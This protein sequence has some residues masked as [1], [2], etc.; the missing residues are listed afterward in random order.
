MD[1]R[2]KIRGMFWG[3]SIGDALGMPVE[4]STADEIAEKYPWTKTYGMNRYIEPKDHK[5]FSNW[6]AGHWTDDTQ[7][8][9]AVAEGICLAN[10]FDVDEF[11]YWQKLEHIRSYSEGGTNGW[12]GTTK[13]ALKALV[14]GESWRSSAPQGKRDG[15]GNG[16]AMK[17]APLAALYINDPSHNLP[18]WQTDWRRLAAYLAMMTHCRGVAVASGFAMFAAALNCLMSDSRTF[19]VSRFCAEVVTA[20]AEGMSYAPDFCGDNIVARLAEL[21]S[22]PSYNR[23][24]IISELKGGC[25]CYESVPFTLMFFIQN[26]TNI[27][28]VYDC[29]AAGGDTD[30][31][32]LMIGALYGALMGEKAFPDDLKAGLQDSAKVMAVADRLCD[33]LGL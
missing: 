19:N 15:Y 7:L 18:D 32:G 3:L 16:V 29:I 2:D 12:G 20:A 31:N 22:W 26:P 8:S 30:S 14:A 21:Y 1:L 11:M 13:N 27:K 5:Y 23:A 17:I 4:M 24:R 28:S 25:Y 6:P 33:R 9:L 10:S